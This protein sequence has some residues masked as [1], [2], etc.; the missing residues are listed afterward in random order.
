MV[1]PGVRPL[2]VTNKVWSD[3]TDIRPTMLSLLGLQDDYVGDGRLLLEFTEAGSATSRGLAEL[4]RI[5]KQINAPVGRFGMSVLQ[6]TTTAIKAGNAAAYAQVAGKLEAL[7][8][9]RDQ[10]AHAIRTMLDN[11][12]S[13]NATNDDD[14]EGLATR[15][16]RLL[17]E[18][19]RLGSG[20]N[21]PTK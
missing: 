6:G 15:A 12:A 1:G 13:R 18:A 20:L 3:H 14:V 19:R 21:Q 9:E 7:G 2:N 11:A 16:R 4:G 8:Q 5:Y 17:A 10:V